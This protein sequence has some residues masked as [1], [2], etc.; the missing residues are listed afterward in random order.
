MRAI[1]EAPA[2]TNLKEL[3]A[4]LGFV[5]YYG[6]FVP[7]Q[8]TV[9]APLYRLLRGQVTWRWTEAEWEAFAKC[10]ELLKELLTSEQVLVLYDPSL[11]LTLAC[12]RGGATNCLHLLYTVPY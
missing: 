10:K 5:N 9:L 4:F 12:E 2:P 6:Q 11:L 8:S 3:Q 7:Q 1:Q